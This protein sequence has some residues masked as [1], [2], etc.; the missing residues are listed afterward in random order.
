MKNNIVILISGSGSN[1]LALAKAASVRHWQ[2]R[3]GAQ[4]AAVISN[5]PDA[6]GLAAAAA[7]G[8]AT[9]ALDHHAF[10]QRC[11][12][13]AAL[14]QRV[15]SYA[16][17]LVLLA[18]FMRVLSAEFVQQFEGRLL[19]IHPSLLPAFTG[20]HTHQRALDAGCQFA[21]ASVHWVTPELDGGPIVRQAV[22][23][24]LAGDNGA[25]LANRVRSQEHVLYP[26]AVEAVLAGRNSPSAM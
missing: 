3:F 19:N 23:P 9:E 24:V 1:M 10:A 26:A 22:V 7:L 8:L 6:P 18:G 25:S 5:R 12:F 15:A 13:D 16:P 2:T 17:T 21:G 20:L 11:D 4:I 14:A